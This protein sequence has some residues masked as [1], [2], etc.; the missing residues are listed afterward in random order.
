MFQATGKGDIYIHVP[1]KEKPNSCILLKDVL[2]APSMGVTLVSISK[3]AGAGSTVVFSG[4][5]CRIFSKD[6]TLLGEIKVKGG[7]YRIYSSVSGVQGYS[8]QTEILSVDELHRRLGH[9]SHERAKL[10]VRK[11][12]VEGIELR[13]GDEVTICESCKSAKAERKSITKVRE[14]ERHSAVGDEVHSDL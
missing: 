4:D 11:G 13:T 7:L 14:G 10:L 12:L 9:I 5:F 1:N 8:A 6:R 2:Y 3:I